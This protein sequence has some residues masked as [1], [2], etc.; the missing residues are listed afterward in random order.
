MV[1]IPGR[2]SFAVRENNLVTIS[3]IG[4]FGSELYL[5]YRSKGRLFKL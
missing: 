4:F 3:K 2:A 1:R 5:Q